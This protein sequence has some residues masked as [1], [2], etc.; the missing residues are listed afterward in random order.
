MEKR[1]RIAVE[2]QLPEAMIQHIQSFMSAKEAA[3]T[4]VLSRSWHA[5]WLTRPSLAFDQ[6]D[7]KRNK[8]AEVAAEAIRR[9]KGLNLKIESFTLQAQSSRANHL[10][11]ELIQGAMEIGATELNL[12]FRPPSFAL[13]PEVLR[14]QTLI[15]LSVKGCEIDGDAV[16]CSKLKSLSLDRVRLRTGDMLILR[17]LISCC[18]SIEELSLSNSLESIHTTNLS[19]IGMDRFHLHKLRRLHLECVGVD[20]SLFENFDSRFP[21]LND[22]TLVRCHGYTAVK[23]CSTSLERVNIV[24]SKIFRGEFQ[25]PNLVYF[26]YSGLSIPSISVEAREWESHVS[27]KCYRSHTCSW[28]LKLQKLLIQLRSSRITLSVNIH[29]CTKWCDVD[30]L[31]EIKDLGRPV[32][33]ENLIIEAPF[34]LGLDLLIGLFWICR[35]KFVTHYWL[36]ESCDYWDGNN[37]SLN[38]IWEVLMNEVTNPDCCAWDEDICGR[39][40]L[41]KVS[42]EVYEEILTEWRPL[43]LKGELDALTAP[44]NK[45]KVRFRLQ[46]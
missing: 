32:V 35:P 1:G 40:G 16:S 46:W 3:R 43:L 17:A 9:Y 27:I 7:F 44:P 6:R 22:L 20:N 41:K 19:L 36:P 37:E 33:V 18:I 8:F 5:A 39:F 15:R 2:N 13:P 10:A 29:V 38:E 21:C 28:Y 31:E 4:A 30:E 34:D 14:S 26:S 25:V 12:E 11:G 23:I 24:Q 42:M 45:R